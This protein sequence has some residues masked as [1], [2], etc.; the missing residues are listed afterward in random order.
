M[1]NQR[2]MM[3]TK[4]KRAR[5]EDEFCDLDESDGDAPKPK[6]KGKAKG[7]KAPAKKR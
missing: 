3:T 1:M 7:T 6:G 2:S 5:N 4:G